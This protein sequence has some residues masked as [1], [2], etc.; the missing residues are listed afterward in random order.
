MF[1]LKALTEQY[2]MD[3]YFSYG[4]KASCITEFYSKNRLKCNDY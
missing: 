3:T 4:K 2:C 1:A